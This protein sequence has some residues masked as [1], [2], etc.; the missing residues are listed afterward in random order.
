MGEWQL[1]IGMDQAVGPSGWTQW[2]VSV[3]SHQ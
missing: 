3:M 2:S 1:E